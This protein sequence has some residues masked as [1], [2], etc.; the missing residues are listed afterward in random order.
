MSNVSFS[1]IIDKNRSTTETNGDQGRIWTGCQS[2]D[3]TEP[4]CFVDGGD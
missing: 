4:R 2:S 1:K 3:L